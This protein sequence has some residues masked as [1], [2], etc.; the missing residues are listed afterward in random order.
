MPPKK[1]QKTGNEKSAG[2]DKGKK[3]GNDK[4]KKTGGKVVIPRPDRKLT[5]GGVPL[6]T[7]GSE[8]AKFLDS[9]LPYL[10]MGFTSTLTSSNSFLCGIYALHQS[11]SNSALP[12]PS[13]AK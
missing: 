7:S 6:D 2:A 12:K 9:L 4:N 3:K 8:N 10:A 13:S 5:E 11:V 1:K